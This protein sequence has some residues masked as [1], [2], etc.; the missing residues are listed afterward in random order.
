MHAC[1]FSKSCK[2]TIR[3]WQIQIPKLR[4]ITLLSWPTITTNNFVPLILTI[5]VVAVANIIICLNRSII[6]IT[7]RTTLIS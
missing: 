4:F 3:A 6:I 1:I 5:Q 7:E 2:L